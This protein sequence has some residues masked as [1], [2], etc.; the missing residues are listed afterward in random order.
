MSFARVCVAV[1][2]LAVAFPSFEIP[3][4]HAG[5]PTGAPAANPAHPVWNSNKAR[6]PKLKHR[7][8]RKVKTSKSKVRAKSKKQLSDD[9]REVPL[10]PDRS[11][12]FLHQPDPTRMD[13]T[14]APPEPRPPEELDAAIG[15]ERHQRAEQAY[16]AAQR[17]L[18]EGKH[19]Q[20]IEQLDMATDLDPAWS[21]PVALR[22]D[23]FGA[24]ALRYEPSE[25][26]LSAQ[27][28]DLQRLLALEPNVEVVQRSQQLIALRKRSEVAQQKEARRRKMVKPALI[29]GS[30]SLA[31]IIGG[32]FLAAGV[33][34]STEPDALR[35]R[36]MVYG[37]ISMLSVG[38]AMAPAAISL[39]VLAG[40]QARRDQATRELNATT[41]RAQPILG[42]SPR[43]YPGG[44]GMGLSLRF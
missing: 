25:M 23:T 12:P 33:Y 16:H 6:T 3:A 19:D 44:G 9:A 21:A 7:S 38:V 14:E 39:G 28:A 20:A 27:A 8:L 13:T 30:L 10:A 2:A 29:V 15:L 17:L 40:K 11:S 37:G 31:L 1:V 32:T 36:S 22:A 43:L 26:L 18:A 5:N 24:L 41:G 34:P 35:Q 42:M 4:A